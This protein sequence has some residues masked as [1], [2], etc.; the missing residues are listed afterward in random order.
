MSIERRLPYE[1]ALRAP[2]LIRYDELDI[3][4][5]QVDGL[6]LSIDLAP[7]ILEFAGADVP[8]YVQGRSILPLLRGSRDEIR[9]VA[10]MEYYSHENPMPWTVN[11]DYRIVRKGPYKYIYWPHFPDLAELYNLDSDPYESTNLI[12]DPAL[13]PI[14]SELRADL[15]EQ[16]VEALGLNV[17]N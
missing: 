16:V 5:A 9:D 10:Y 4:A 7:T 6:V 8:G 13:T 14:I 11:L 12:G 2:L 3:H 15:A 17:N 1:E